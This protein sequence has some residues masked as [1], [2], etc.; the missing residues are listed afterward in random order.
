[1]A[2]TRAILAVD[3]D[4][5]NRSWARQIHLEKP[6]LVNDYK[7]AWS[8]INRLDGKIFSALIHVEDYE[9]GLALA[10]FAVKMACLYIAV[11][12]PTTPDELNRVPFVMNQHAL[13][14]LSHRDEFVVNGTMDWVT[15]YESVTTKGPVIVTSPY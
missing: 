7:T 3:D 15:L 14:V 6:V 12:S 9:K 4:E 1:M 11:T 10:V 2:K 8:T 5:A 13:V